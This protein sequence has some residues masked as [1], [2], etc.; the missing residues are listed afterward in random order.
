MSTTAGTIVMNV[1]DIVPDPHY[2]DVGNPTPDAD[3]NFI[4]AQTLYR[5]LN[6]AVRVA[7]QAI[8]AGIIDWIALPQRAGQP[9]YN[10]P[11]QFMDLQSGFSNQW[12]IDKISLLEEDVIW[13]S[14]S[15]AAGQALWGYYRKRADFLQFGLWPV[16]GTTDPVTTLAGGIGASGADPI[17]LA[18]TLN[19]LS[20]GY[21]QIDNEII[22][23]QQVVG[24]SLAVISRG[25]CGT[26]AASHANGATVQHLGLWLKGKRTA[27]QITS[28][29]SLV[30][31]PDDIVSH[32]ETY[33]LARCRMSENEHAEGRN[34]MNDFEKACKALR[35]DPT[36][37]TNQG[38][39][40]AYGEPV[41]GPLGWNGQVIVP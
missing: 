37:K 14:T 24:N 19:F 33:L 6:D 28:S 4:R 16:P 38:Q 15:Q 41:I 20:F 13:P 40:R 18:S 36:R 1:T 8:D 23:Y 34:L 5:W 12:P 31:L 32:V 39:I 29:T 2:D 9:Y 10:V 17:A 27:A 35:G 25:S 11:S 30:E 22:N 3:T 7:A 26:T 21:V